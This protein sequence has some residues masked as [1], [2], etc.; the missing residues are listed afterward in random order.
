MPDPV[1]IGAIF[2]LGKAAIERIW[3]DE[4]KRAEEMR[5]LE[6]LRQNGDLEKMQLHVQLMLAQI[7]VNKEDARSGNWFQASWRPLI[8][9]FGGFSLF[10]AGFI[11]PLLTWIWRTLQATGDIPAD[12]EPPPF[13]ESGTL[14]AVVT[15]M[16]GIGSMRSYDKQKGTD[17][18]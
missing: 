5:K 14:G 15:G 3:P 9:Y 7:D 8:G 1:T 13:V 18:K 4:N 10:Y 6:E 16:L 2:N 11:Y 12:V 17:T